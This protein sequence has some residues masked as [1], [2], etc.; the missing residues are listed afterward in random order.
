MIKQ[1]TLFLGLSDK[2]TKTQKIDV[3]EAYKLVENVLIKNGVEGYTIY[4]CVGGYLHA[5]KKFIRE[6]SLR[7]EL[8]FIT[9]EQVL[10]ITD[11]LKIVFNQESIALIE[12]DINSEL[13]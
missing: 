7:I 1:F 3:L 9:R 6:N 13:V 2:D 11:T 4:N 10:S 8:L 12:S 5:D